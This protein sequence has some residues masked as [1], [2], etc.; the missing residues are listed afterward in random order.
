M[1]GH[2]PLKPRMLVRAQ[3][4]QPTI[5]V[6]C[7]DVVLTALLSRCA[8]GRAAPRRPAAA[9]PRP[10]PRQHGGDPGDSHLD[11]QGHRGSFPLGAELGWSRQANPASGLSKL[12]TGDHQP[13]PQEALAAFPG[14][15][16]PDLA[17]GCV[18]GLYTG[19]RLGD[20][21]ATQGEPL[22][23][24]DGSPL[25]FSFSNPQS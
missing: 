16:P 19:Q 17:R 7:L 5:F 12:K 4:P 22:A 1:V 23:L 3:L 15:L 20:K 21:L 10:A 11:A 14:A 25:R 13:W 8:L 18:L 9:A 24:S 6:L 2:R